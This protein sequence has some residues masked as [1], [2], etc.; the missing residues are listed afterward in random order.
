MFSLIIWKFIHRLHD[1]V[2]IGGGY[3]NL[4]YLNRNQSFNNWTIIDIPYVCKLQN[5][6]FNNL[7]IDSSKYK[8]YSAYDYEDA[9]KTYDLIIG[10]HSISELSIDA[11]NKYFSS[12]IKTCSYF[13]YSYHKYA[14]KEMVELKRRIIEEQFDLMFEV[15]TENNNVSTCLFK[16]KSDT[17]K[18]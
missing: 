5:W 16:N 6:M 12:I 9:I 7:G 13:L 2:E 11:F 15:N 8:L 10:T 1:I 3:G 17:R 14:H 4:F 18:V